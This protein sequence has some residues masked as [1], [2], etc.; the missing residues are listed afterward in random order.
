MG[1]GEYHPQEGEGRKK[2]SGAVRWWNI[3]GGISA[4]ITV[5]GFLGL[6]GLDQPQPALSQGTPSTT[7]FAP[8]PEIDTTTI[9]ASSTTTYEPESSATTSFDPAV[10]DYGS[11]D[12]TP[13]TPAALLA[14]T[15]TSDL[16]NA[17]TLVAAGSEPCDQA[18]GISSAAEN[19]LTGNGCTAVMTGEYLENGASYR[20]DVLV[21]VQ[22]I[23]F[24]SAST[25]NQVYQFIRENTL[26]YGI[27][28]P[29]NGDG[30]ATCA[31]GYATATK[32]QWE[33]PNHRYLILA[34]ALYTDLSSDSTVFPWVNAAAQKADEVCGPQNYAGN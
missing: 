24:E 13:F 33:G 4:I 18:F 17:F 1:T 2:K 12:R 29:P 5:L 8:P 25:A 16:N 31:P 19:V 28:C 26:L 10:L 21:S 14:Q 3:A 9:P 34:T 30:S 6:H 7:A 27:W 22:V 11:T 15:F 32:S 20:N 23:A